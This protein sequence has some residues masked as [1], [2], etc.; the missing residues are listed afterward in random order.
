MNVLPIVLTLL[1]LLGLCGLI[2]PDDALL[3]GGTVALAGIVI[4][5]LLAFRPTFMRMI[6]WSKSHLL[7]SQILVTI[8]QLCLIPMSLYAGYN[9]HELGIE[10]SQTGYLIFGALFVLSI[11]NIPLFIQ[12][13]WLTLPRE[14]Q[15]Q[16]FA[17]VGITVSTIAIII[18]FGNQIPRQHPESIYM[19]WLENVDQVI[20]QEDV[21][22]I[23]H[24]SLFHFASQRGSESQAETSD[25]DMSI[26]EKKRM[27]K[28]K[29]RKRRKLRKAIG[30]GICILTVLFVLLLAG[31]VCV[32][33]CL[34]VI[35]ESA[36]GI[37]LGVA[38]VPLAIWGMVASIKMCSK[39]RRKI[40]EQKSKN[41]S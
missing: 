33:V 1:G 11:F 14:F 35:S 10:F 34:I 19:S 37:L 29:K 6:R 39:A 16:R 3:F 31:A 38:I 4:V 9:L 25:R 18:L 26:K 23:A 17:V 12:H 30:A 15:K 28:L 32:G 27:K 41:S 40:K 20:F 24:T 2:F 13:K 8:V 5:L 36:G 7:Q 22:A 21:P